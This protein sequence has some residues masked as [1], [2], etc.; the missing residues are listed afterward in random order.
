MSLYR[1]VISRQNQRSN[2]AAP[3]FRLKFTHSIAMDWLL[4]T[5][6]QS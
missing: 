1:M 4:S 6:G 5:I 3:F 2:P